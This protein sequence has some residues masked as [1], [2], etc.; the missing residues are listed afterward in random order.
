M[1]KLLYSFIW[2]GNMIIYVNSR[3]FTPDKGILTVI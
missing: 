2:Q 1:Y 3:D